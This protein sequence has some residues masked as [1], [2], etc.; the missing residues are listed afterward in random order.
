MEERLGFSS[1]LSRTTL[2]ELSSITTP[3]VDAVGTPGIDSVS[4]I[5]SIETRT[6]GGSVTGSSY[7]IVREDGKLQNSLVQTCVIHDNILQIST[8]ND[9]IAGGSSTSPDV[10]CSSSNLDAK[11]K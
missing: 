5:V 2:E 8:K 3:R 1:P 11:V 7:A 6:R 4:G 9:G 10:D